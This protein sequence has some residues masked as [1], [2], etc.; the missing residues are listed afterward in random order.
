MKIEESKLFLRLIKFNNK[1]SKNKLVPINLLKLDT[2][3]IRD[4]R[5]MLFSKKY[6]EGC[7]LIISMED[8]I[9][10]MKGIVDQEK[11]KTYNV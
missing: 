2:M 8:I 3:M 1:M 11:L 7:D 6:R 10:L 9:K 4:N 5:I